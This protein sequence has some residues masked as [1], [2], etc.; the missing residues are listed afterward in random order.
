MSALPVG[1]KEPVVSPEES[2]KKAVRL[3]EEV[4][5]L[6]DTT[7]APAD[8]GALVQTAHD[9]LERYIAN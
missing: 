9:E 2:L 4:L 3:L 7:S 5:R 8:L 1:A 6:V